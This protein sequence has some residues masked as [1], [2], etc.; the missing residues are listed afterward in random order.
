MADETQG[1]I[2]R[3]LDGA[4][5]GSGV[6]VVVTV[7]AGA[8]PPEYLL[9]FGLLL[10]VISIFRAKIFGKWK[11]AFL[12]NVM[13][14][15]GIVVGTAEMWKHIAKPEPPATKSDFVSALKQLADKTQPQSPISISIPPSSIPNGNKPITKPELEQFFQ[16][17]VASH[18][19]PMAGANLSN[20]QLR[21]Q[22]KD[23]ADRLGAKEQ[24]YFE[25]KE[26]YEFLASKRM[27]SSAPAKLVELMKKFENDTEYQ[28]LVV[29]A[30]FLW[31]QLSIRLNLKRPAEKRFGTVFPN[32]GSP[33]ATNQ[34]REMASKLAP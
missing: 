27:D 28:D 17:Y 7:M 22:A 9:G 26:R 31:D 8:L 24:E 32:A 33:L 21:T 6:G 20:E 5:F 11:A 30:D 18:S 4:L 25:L 14:S 2:W 23:V 1:K 15:V 10:I 13:L 29:R 3:L 16:Q 12:A 19:M 34:L